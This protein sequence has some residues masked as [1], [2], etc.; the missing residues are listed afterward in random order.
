[1]AI[2]VGG[3]TKLFVGELIE[4]AM[5]VLR[6]NGSNG[7]LEASH[8]EEAARRLQQEGKFGHVPEKSFFFSACGLRPESLP[9]DNDAEICAIDADLL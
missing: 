6:E 4:T 3:L 2:V 9:S 1:M 8:I 7:A 5:V